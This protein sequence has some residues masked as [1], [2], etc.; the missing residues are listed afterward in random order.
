[1]LRADSRQI[2]SPLKGHPIMEISLTKIYLH[3]NCFSARADDSRE[4]AGDSSERASD[5][6]ESAGDNGK[7][8]RG[9]LRSM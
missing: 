5:S 4:S 2:L 1:M 9:F 6:S 3:L 7:D 8:D